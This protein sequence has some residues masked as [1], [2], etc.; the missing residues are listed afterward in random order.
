MS[1]KFTLN[2]YPWSALAAALAFPAMLAW[3]G[4][5]EA[6]PPSQTGPELE[7]RFAGSVR[8][9][10][11]EY[12]VSCHGKEKPQAQLDLTVYT[13]MASVAKDSAHWVLVQEKLAAKQM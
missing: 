4:G 11:Q 10:L 9:L 12:C 6:A 3:A 1:C 13:T 5:S 8:P 7:R 2:P